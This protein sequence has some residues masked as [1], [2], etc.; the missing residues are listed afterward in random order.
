MDAICVER[1]AVFI[2]TSSPKDSEIVWIQ[3]CKTT[4]WSRC[5]KIFQLSFP[6]LY[7][8]S[9]LN[10]ILSFAMNTLYYSLQWGGATR[11][12][13]QRHIFFK[14]LQLYFLATSI[15][16]HGI[17]WTDPIV[18]TQSK[19]ATKNKTRVFTYL[20]TSC[21]HRVYIY[22]CERAFTFVFTWRLHSC[23]HVFGPRLHDVCMFTL[24]CFP[25]H[26][27]SQMDIPSWHRRN[28]DPIILMQMDLN[29]QYDCKPYQC[30]LL[31]FVRPL[32]SDDTFSWSVLKFC[33]DVFAI[34][35]LILSN[36][37]HQQI[38]SFIQILKISLIK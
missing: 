13:L 21:S 2:L 31:I 34:H 16:H 1:S 6:S 17:V 18:L 4:P 11:P 9:V 36:V 23:L 3:N 38:L 12:T 5:T 25:L 24:S 37:L 8:F 10:L 29:G 15:A 26:A 28:G 32:Q 22:G 30:L 19:H 20:F 27:Y 33:E 14:T 7:V 35:L